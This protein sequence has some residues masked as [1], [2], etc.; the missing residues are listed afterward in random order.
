MV[1]VYKCITSKAEL[2]DDEKVIEEVYGG[3]V[4]KVQGNNVPED[5]NEPDGDKVLDIPRDYLYNKAEGYKKSDF[6][7][8][9]KALNKSIMASLE[10]KSEEYKTG[11]KENIKLFF[12][13]IVKNFKET[14]VYYNDKSDQF[15]F[16]YMPV[17]VWE[18]GAATPTF[19]YIKDAMKKTKC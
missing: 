10:D 12:K 1:Y 3:Y 16:S 6:K 4:L 9:F 8:Y 14:D 17:A 7:T 5:E 19:Y 2:L 15:P 13:F 18:D 11:F